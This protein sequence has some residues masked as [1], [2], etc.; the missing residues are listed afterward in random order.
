[1][2]NRRWH[3]AVIVH[4]LHAPLKLCTGV[5]SMYN[6]DEGRMTNDE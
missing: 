4:H 1:V 6:D 5:D 3:S 2:L